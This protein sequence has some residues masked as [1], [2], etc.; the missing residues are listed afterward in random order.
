MGAHR[1]EKVRVSVVVAA[2]PVLALGW[3]SNG[4]GR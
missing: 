1:V 3:A 2:E 4:G